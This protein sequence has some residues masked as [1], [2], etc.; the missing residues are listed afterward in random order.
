MTYPADDYPKSKGVD[1]P[2]GDGDAVPDY[3]IARKPA[4]QS[5]PPQYPPAYYVP[6][7]YP[8]VN[9]YQA[10]KDAEDASRIAKVIWLMLLVLGIIGGIFFVALLV[11]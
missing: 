3:P 6:V 7:Y 11:R 2:Y 9:P 5:P 8:A 4:R 1:Y 10:A